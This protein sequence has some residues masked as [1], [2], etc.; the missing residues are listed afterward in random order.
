MRSYDRHVAIVDY[1]PAVLARYRQI[2]TDT[3]GV[4]R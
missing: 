2:T 1:V 3:V 4:G